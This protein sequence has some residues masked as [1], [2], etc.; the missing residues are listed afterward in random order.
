[1]K[2]LSA[3]I[4][5]AFLLI[6]LAL[7]AG[8]SRT[9]KKFRE[10]DIPHI[11]SLMRQAHSPTAFHSSGRGG[12]QLTEDD[13]KAC[14]GKSWDQNCIRR[15]GRNHEMIIWSNANHTAQGQGI[16]LANLTGRLR[17]RK[18]RL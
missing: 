3:I 15:Q 6:A 17:H 12:N 9:L 14:L 1:M 18:G 16:R 13:I 8:A 10:S 7:S 11:R 5:S 4:L 2:R